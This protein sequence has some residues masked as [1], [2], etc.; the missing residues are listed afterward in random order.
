MGILRRNDLCGP[1]SVVFYV[2]DFKAYQGYV[3]ERRAAWWDTPDVDDLTR[4]CWPN[5]PCLC[6]KAA[7]P[8]EA[9]VR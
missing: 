7:A 6:D 5:A 9:V 2:A 1:N 3:N 8:T 4:D